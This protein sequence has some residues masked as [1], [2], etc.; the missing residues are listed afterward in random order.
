MRILSFIAL[1]CLEDSISVLVFSG[2]TTS[3]LGVGRE[4]QEAMRRMRKRVKGKKVGILLIMFK[5]ILLPHM[6]KKFRTGH[7][8]LI[9]WITLS[10]Q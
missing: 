1:T 4:T 7:D 3:C 10:K 9:P 6:E 2:E 5:T 8:L